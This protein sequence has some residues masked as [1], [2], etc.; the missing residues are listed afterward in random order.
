MSKFVVL[1][2][3]RYDSYDRHWVTRNTLEEAEKVSNEYTKDHKYN[4]EIYEI[5]QML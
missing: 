4:T 3:N 1:I 2:A 5:G